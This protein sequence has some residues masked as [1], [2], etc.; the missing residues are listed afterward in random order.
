M[1]YNKFKQLLLGGNAFN[2]LTDT[3][4]VALMS[5]AYDPG[6][7]DSFWGDIMAQEVVGVGYPAGGVVLTGKTVVQSDDLTFDALD[8]TLN[9]TTGT[10]VKSLVIYR[11]ITNPADSELIMVKKFSFPKTVIAGTLKIEWAPLGILLLR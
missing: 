3:L 7:G 8:I 11:V 1:I 10:Q 4:K 2:P 5:P 9:I 6:L